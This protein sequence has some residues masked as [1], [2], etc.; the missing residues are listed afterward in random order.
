M[1]FAGASSRFGRAMRL[2]DA[3]VRQCGWP[4]LL[5]D[6]T[7]RFNGAIGNAIDRFSRAMELSKVG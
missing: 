5:A 6:A 7:G 3:A 1:L 2:T 4:V